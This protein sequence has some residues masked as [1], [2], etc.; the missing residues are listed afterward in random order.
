MSSLQSGALHNDP[1]RLKEDEIF[2]ADFKGFFL[3]RGADVAGNGSG[4]DPSPRTGA[5][6]AGEIASSF[7]A[8][9]LV[10]G[11]EGKQPEASSFGMV[12]VFSLFFVSRDRRCR[13]WNRRCEG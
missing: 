9:S 10:E 8:V 6:L 7:V 1:C 12:V 13:A 5:G 11:A 4:I 2:R 3:G